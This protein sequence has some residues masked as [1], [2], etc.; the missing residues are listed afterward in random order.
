V[1]RVAEGAKH[2]LWIYTRNLEPALHEREP[3]LAE[4]KRVA[5][6]GTRRRDSAC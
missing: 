6:S 4:L 1:L 2:R 5:L 3:F